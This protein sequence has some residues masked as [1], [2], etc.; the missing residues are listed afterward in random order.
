MMNYLMKV[1]RDLFTSLSRLFYF[2]HFFYFDQSKN[3][4]KNSVSDNVRNFQSSHPKF[5]G[6]ASGL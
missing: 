2:L 6:K 1:S 4:N 3:N 5:G